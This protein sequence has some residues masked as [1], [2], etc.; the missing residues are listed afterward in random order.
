MLRSLF[1]FILV[2]ASIP[3]ILMWPHVGV[4]V[5]SWISYMSPH[6]LTYGI[7][8]SFDFLDYVG[9]A[10][11]LSAFITREPKRLPHHPLVYLLLIYLCWITLTT[12]FAVEEK[13]AWAKWLVFIKIYL[14]TFLTLMFMN[15]KVRLKGL[16][17]VIIL[18]IGFFSTKG[19]LF[20]LLLG[21]EARVWGPEGTFI[22]DNNDFGLVCVMLLPLIRFMYMH[23]ENKHLKRA[24]L[25]M[26]GGT[27][28]SIFGTQSRGAFLALTAI[29]LF[30][31]WKSKRLVFG[32]SILIFALAIGFAFMP[33]S[34]RARMDSIQN[35]QQD[36][37][38]EGRLTMWK[39]AIDVA[40]DHPVL[41]GGFEVFYNNEYRAHYLPF[42]VEGRA[43]HSI[44][45]EVLGEHGYLGLVLFLLIM[46]TT[47]FTCSTV[48]ARTRDEPDMTWYRDLAAMIQ[49]SIIGYGVAGAFLNLATFDLYYHLIAIVVILRAMS[50]QELSV[51]KQAALT[52][53]DANQPLGLGAGTVATSAPLS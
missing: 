27:L 25:V 32:I 30:M 22:G 42:G 49:V 35:Y 28:L 17:W 13:M 7:A 51:K 21:G 18:S 41:G 15:T 10:T 45:F 24:L 39:F 47:Y 36:A 16:L 12:F 5:W 29:L 14:F 53:P 9:G 8:Y 44:Y 50:D 26:G 23:T 1:V 6:R 48:I 46:I 40:N 11:I 31:A 37:S 20:T 19:G 33:E 3:L 52:Q 2:F 4:L 34:W 43:V 38:A